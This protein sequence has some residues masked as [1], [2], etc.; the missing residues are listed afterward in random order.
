MTTAVL[1][2]GTRLGLLLVCAASS[3]C[4]IPGGG[5]TMRTGLDVRRYHKPSAFLELVDTRWDEYNRVAE[6][7]LLGGPIDPRAVVTPWCPPNGGGMGLPPGMNGAP[8]LAPMT[9]PPNGA[10]E[11]NG[12]EPN[13][14]PGAPVETLPPPPGVGPTAQRPQGDDNLMRGP[15]RQNPEP[16]ASPDREA[17]ATESDDEADDDAETRPTSPDESGTL[18]SYRRIPASNA[19]RAALPVNRVQPV[20]NRSL[21]SYRRPTASRLFSPTR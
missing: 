21:D 5:W 3:G 13:P 8:S 10:G 15:G 2:T 6:M 9:T 11:T 4:Y 1:R 12:Q 16:G 20:A 17:A 7:N 18:S 19:V 14:L